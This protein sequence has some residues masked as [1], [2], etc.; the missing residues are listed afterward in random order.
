V[1]VHVAANEFTIQ[2]LSFKPSLFKNKSELSE[3]TIPT[4]FASYKFIN[5]SLSKLSPKAIEFL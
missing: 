5:N 4:I 3:Q 1:S 2:L